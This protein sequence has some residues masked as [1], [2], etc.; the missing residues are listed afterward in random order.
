MP[1]LVKPVG[2]SPSIYKAT[3]GDVPAEP[4]PAPEVH[5]TQSLDNP[6]RRLSEDLSRQ[7][8]RWTVKRTIRRLTRCMMGRM[9]GRMTRRMMVVASKIGA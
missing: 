7:A 8:R 6:P 4:R 9:M 2:P 5:L 1:D 3:D